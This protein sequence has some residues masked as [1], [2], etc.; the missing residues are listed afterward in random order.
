MES[1]N[2]M[3]LKYEGGLTDH[4]VID[5]VRFGQSIQGVGKLYSSVGHFLYTGSVLKPRQLSMVRVHATES[6]AGCYEIGAMLAVVGA[7][8]DMFF[9]DSVNAYRWL[10]EKIVH[11][12]HGEGT[13]R[14]DYEKTAGEIMDKANE[15]KAVSEI[16]AHGL[17][18]ANSEQKVIQSELIAALR[19]LAMS[20]QPALRQA[21][22]PVG[23]DCNTLTQLG[24]IK[25]TEADA[26]AIRSKEDLEVGDMQEY[27]CERISSLDTETGSCKLKI[28]GIEG[29]I[30]GK[31]SD[32]VLFIPHNLYSQALDMHSPLIISAKPLLKD[33]A[34]CK[35]Y[36][37]DAK[38][39]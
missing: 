1:N 23:R 16:L 35:L 18:A 9:T 28:E 26:D 8:Q 14:A 27:R 17:V 13:G 33:G 12:I 7:T 2:V 20:N 29:V 10:M 38:A 15:D 4:H 24:S 6:G 36:I 30:S 5:A 21:V 19:D 31:I 37:A 3:I 25:T 32:P 39:V 11:L 34:I 22:A